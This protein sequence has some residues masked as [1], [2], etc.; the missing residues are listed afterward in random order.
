[1]GFVRTIKNQII[2]TFEEMKLEMAKLT[3]KTQIDIGI[4]ID[5]YSSQVKEVKQEVSDVKNELSEIKTQI[6]EILRVVKAK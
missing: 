1:M 6:S 5:R 4:K 2:Y 3:T